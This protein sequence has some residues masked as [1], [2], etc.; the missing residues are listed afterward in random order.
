MNIVRYVKAGHL[1]LERIRCGY[2]GS[3]VVQYFQ[4]IL[5]SFLNLRGRNTFFSR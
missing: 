5:S 3:T 2:S 4:D 1:K